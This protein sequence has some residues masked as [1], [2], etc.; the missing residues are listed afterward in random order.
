M[1]KHFQITEKNRYDEEHDYRITEN[2]LQATPIYKEIFYSLIYT[3]YNPNLKEIYLKRETLHI[4]HAKTL[5]HKL[6]DLTGCKHTKAAVIL[7]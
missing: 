1:Q 3:C 5:R 6:D 7:L 2:P 4:T